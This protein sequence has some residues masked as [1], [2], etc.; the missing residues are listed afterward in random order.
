[1][2]DLSLGFTLPVRRSFWS[3]VALLVGYA[4]LATDITGQALP[5]DSTAVTLRSAPAAE[6]AAYRDNPR[7][8]Y[9]KG[10]VERPSPIASLLSRRWREFLRGLF[11][12]G[13][14]R[15]LLWLFA[16]AVAVFV[17]SMLIGTDTRSVFYRRERR[18]PV[19]V[20][21]AALSETD[22]AQLIVGAESAGEYREAV[23]L[24]FLRA[25]KGL[26]R[27][28]LIRWTIEKTNRTYARELR[29]SPASN[30]L[31]A[32]FDRI[33]SWFDYCWYGHAAVDAEMYAQV[34][35]A[36]S[37]FEQRLSAFTPA[38]EPGQ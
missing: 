33:V 29:R 22:F 31:D 38:E 18:L 8:D 13:L 3:A 15:P 23:R 17:I 27:N 9:T 19:S 16:L 36:F 26:E 1:V 34:G 11:G 20:E 35:D 37:E 25:L 10:R 28:G 5:P 21:E 12:S 7:F 32:P 30:T 6:L 24:R 14:A 2:P 4:L